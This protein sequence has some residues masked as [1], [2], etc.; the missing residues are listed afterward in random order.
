M[1]ETDPDPDGISYETESLALENI[2]E[3][4]VS[5]EPDPERTLS[6]T[7]PLAL[8]N[9]GEP[10]LSETQPALKPGWMS[11]EIDPAALARLSDM[12]PVPDSKSSSYPAAESTPARSARSAMLL[13]LSTIGI[14]E[15]SNALSVLFCA[16]AKGS[17]TVTATPLADIAAGPW[18]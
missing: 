9:I 17:D 15:S 14:P 13:S 1:S 10:R 12:E 11:S 2:D 16:L 7:E 4:S 6:E 3:P 5:A 18:A 8:E